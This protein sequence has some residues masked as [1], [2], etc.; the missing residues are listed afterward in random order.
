MDKR[1]IY[2]LIILIIG[3][4][5]LFLIVESSTTVG[6]ATVKVNSFLVT[7]P[8][9]FN[10]DSTGGRYAYLINRNTHESI[11]I[12]D[13]GK[14]NFIN[15]NMSQKWD[16][17]S[18]DNENYKNVKNITH[19]KNISTMYYED[20]ND[21]LNQITFLTKYKHTFYIKSEHFHDNYTMEKCVKSA[22][23]SISPNYKQ[24]QED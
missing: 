18:N 14:G 16:L 13:L 12:Y 3:I 7:V 4:S 20:C 2:I 1:W 6:K 17:I 21:T 10:I 22:I 9:S 15:K 19:E 23:D 8:D 5:C 11:Y 24:K